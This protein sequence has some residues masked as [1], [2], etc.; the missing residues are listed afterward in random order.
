MPRR[1]FAGGYYQAD[2]SRE[3]DGLREVDPNAEIPPPNLFGTALEGDGSFRLKLVEVGI[4]QGGVSSLKRRG[5]PYEP[6][7]DTYSVLN[8]T[9]DRM[10]QVQTGEK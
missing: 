2:S 4:S 9:N 8:T 3:I 10:N 5:Q 6:N 7:T 1:I